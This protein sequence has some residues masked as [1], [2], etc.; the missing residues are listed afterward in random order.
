MGVHPGDAANQALPLLRERDGDR[1][2]ERTAERDER[3]DL[4]P[5]RRS[6]A[7][8]QQDDAEQHADEGGSATEP[9]ATAGASRAVVP[10]RDLLEDDT[11][12]PAMP[13]T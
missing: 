3:H 7:L 11:E 10:E 4:V 5:C 9:V 13:T 2:G 6:Q 8:F 1:R 12:R